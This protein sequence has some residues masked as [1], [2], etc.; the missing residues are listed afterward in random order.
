MV[1]SNKRLIA[2]FNFWV[3]FDEWNV[4]QATALLLGYNPIY[5][6]LKYIREI[7]ENETT[8]GNLNKSEASV[9]THEY[10]KMQ[11]LL[12]DSIHSGK[13]KSRTTPANYY[14]WALKKDIPLFIEFKDA[15]EERG[16]RLSKSENNPFDN[17]KRNKQLY[18]IILSMAVKYKFNPDQLKN[19]STSKF[20]DAIHRA[21][22]EI[23]DNTIRDVVRKSY[24]IYKDKLD[25][26]VF[27]N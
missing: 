25:H 3:K 7:S 14:K 20:R 18:K 17:P 23:D 22:L 9:F 4:E 2:D 27:E 8:T 26:S 13:L 11:N 10:F 24:E 12:F 16:V 6:D 15:I 19:P 5:V 1:Q 21:G